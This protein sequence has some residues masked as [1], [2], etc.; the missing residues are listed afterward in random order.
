M[1]I[2]LCKAVTDHDIE[3]AVAAGAS[4]LEQVQQ[5][6][7]VSTGCGSCSSAAAL[8]VAQ[9]LTNNSSHNSLNPSG[10]NPSGFKIGQF[11]PAE[12]ASL[13]YAA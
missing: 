3:A 4:S 8:V 6:L 5:E 12:V 9:A 10:Y 13:V 7:G 11:S 1:Y 2:C